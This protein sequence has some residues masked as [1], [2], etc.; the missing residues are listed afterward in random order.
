MTRIAVCS[1]KEEYLNGL[2][3]EIKS[4][5]ESNKNNIIRINARIT[6]EVALHIQYYFARLEGYTIDIRFCMNCTN[7]CDI[8]IEFV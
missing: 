3:A 8:R 5:R 6:T 4:A 1:N 7:Q 2:L